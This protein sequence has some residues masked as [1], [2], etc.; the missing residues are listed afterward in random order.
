MDFIV[1]A[2]R[3][4]PADAYLKCELI[5]FEL[6]NYGRQPTSVIEDRC[7]KIYTDDKFILQVDKL[8]ALL[9]LLSNY[10]ETEKFQRLIMDDLKEKFSNE[11]LYWQVLAQR[12][13]KG[14]ITYKK[15]NVPDNLPISQKTRMEV[16][17]KVYEKACELVCEHE[18]IIIFCQ[19]LI[20]FF[21]FSFLD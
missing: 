12:E 7:I 21:S 18:H 8:A 20:I 13:L 17:V 15:E 16:F 9:E 5:D 1:R 6:S 10:P 19:T 4:H 14:Q 2:L 11:E 3:K